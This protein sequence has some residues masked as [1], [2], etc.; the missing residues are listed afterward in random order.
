MVTLMAMPAV[1]V[2]AV[3]GVLNAFT[4]RNRNSTWNPMWG[5]AVALA[6]MALLPEF[7]ALICYCYIAY[8][9]TRAR[10]S[11][12]RGSAESGYELTSNDTAR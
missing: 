8:R 9:R 4:S 3:Y 12:K 10:D 2:R 1:V 11:S 7:L 5:S 6:L